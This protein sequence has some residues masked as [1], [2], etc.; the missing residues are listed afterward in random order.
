[1][2][3]RKGKAKLL[4][5]GERRC[6]ERTD[7]EMKKDDRDSQADIATL[8][9]NRDDVNDAIAHCESAK[10]RAAKTLSSMKLRAAARAS[11]EVK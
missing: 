7:E 8:T 10:L 4:L 1:L 3:L 11:K 6:P 2:H 9:F 5:Q